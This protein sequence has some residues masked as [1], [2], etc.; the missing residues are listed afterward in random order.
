MVEVNWSA[1]A[2]DD[3]NDVWRYIA[4]DSVRYADLMALKFTGSTR[5][6]RTHPKLGK[7]VP[8]LG[9]PDVRE[10]LIEG[11]RL[12]YWIENEFRV[13]VVALHKQIRDRRSTDIA[14]RIRHIASK[15]GRH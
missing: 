9:R 8:K 7:P 13:H 2:L 14:S 11:Y 5:L 1:R 15:R 6:L 3:L 10:L 12:V 4:Q